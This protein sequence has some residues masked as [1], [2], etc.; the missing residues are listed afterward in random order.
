M[1]TAD[2]ENGI[3]VCH[4]FV[5]WPDAKHSALALVTWHD[6]AVLELGRVLS[7]HHALERIEQMCLSPVFRFRVEFLD[8]QCHFP[9]ETSQ[10]N[11]LHQMLQ[12]K[13][14]L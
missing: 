4:V 3:I 14:G 12:S 11:I 10:P 13:Q 6:H 9:S 7:D 5:G 1:A 8:E 2:T